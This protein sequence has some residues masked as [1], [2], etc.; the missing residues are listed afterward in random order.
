MILVIVLLVLMSIP[1]VLKLRTPKI[2][3]KKETWERVHRYEKRTGKPYH[4]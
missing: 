2:K 4:Y 1:I 3:A